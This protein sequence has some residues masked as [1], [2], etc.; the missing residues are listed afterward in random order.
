MQAFS[1]IKVVEFGQVLAAPFASLQLGLLGAD[2]IKVEPVKGGDQLRDRLI[3]GPG[4]ED[5]MATAFLGMNHNKKSLALDLKS[6]KGQAIA[7][8]LIAQSDVVIHNFRAGIVERLGLDA[9]TLQALKPDLVICALS[10]FGQKGPKSADAAYDGAIQAMSGMMAG[11]GSMQTG[12]MRTT[13][14]PVDMMTGM[15]AAFAIASALFRRAQTG[16]GQYIDVAM[17]D[18][19]LLLQATSVNQY[20]LDGHLAQLTG[21]GSITGLP[22]ADGFATKEGNILLAATQIHH[23]HILFEETGLHDLRD[24]EDLQTIAGL[25]KHRTRVQNS[26]RAAF[27]DDTAQNWEIRLSRRGIPIA[28]VNNLAETTALEQLQYRDIIMKAP[29]NRDADDQHIV[30]SGFTLDQDG[31]A[32]T[33]PVPRLGAQSEQILEGLGYGSEDIRMLLKEGVVHQASPHED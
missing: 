7:H 21:N 17:L 14:L 4:S 24:D 26:L 6:P 13:Y 31:A 12:P 22:M 29:I 15:T 23:A 8:R 5:G 30:A 32:I 27:L 9:P 3:P 19:A 20:L 11:N 16:D 2:V 28:K 10:G 25:I 33:K 1:E 18:A